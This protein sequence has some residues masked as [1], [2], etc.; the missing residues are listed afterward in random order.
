MKNCVDKKTLGR[1]VWRSFFLQAAWN[2]EGQQNLGLAAAM[3]PALRKIHGAG[4]PALSGALK[5]CL[6]RFNTHPYMSG[7]I[8]GALI[9][10]E[11][12]GPDNGMTLERM[13]K[14]KTALATAFA[15]IGDAFFWN[16]LWPAAAVAALFWALQFR[17]TGA[18]VFLVIMNIAHLVVRFM[19][20]WLGY[21]GGLSVTTAVS[22][23][24]LPHQALRLRLVLAAAAGAL[25]GYTLHAAAPA[26]I[27]PLHL[28]II[29]I[30]VCPGIYLFSRLV[31]RSVPIE[32]LVYGVLVLLVTGRYLINIINWT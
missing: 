4:T 13:G 16:A 25:A 5:R 30:L 1:V 29:G 10:S 19:G 23:L 15:A 2:R 20:F 6:E 31:R 22:R 3:L 26:F 8:L 7:P 17:I 11:L 32:A 18:V 27:P 21:R 28:V 12:T 24:S 14:I 9:R